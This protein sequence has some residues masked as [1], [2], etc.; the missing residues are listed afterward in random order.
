M[1]QLWQ[2]QRI[3]PVTSRETFQELRDALQ[4]PKFG[5]TDSEILDLI[6]SEILPYFEVIDPVEE[7]KNVC[8]DPGDD[9]FIACAISAGVNY[10]VTGDRDLVD[11]TRYKNMR[12]LTVRE[13]LNLFD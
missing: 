3:V 9:K 5:L 7:I 10:L 11:L 13:F 2:E 8:R 6:E 4:Y 1:V 12:I